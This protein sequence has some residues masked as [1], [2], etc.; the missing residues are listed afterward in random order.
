MVNVRVEIET[1]TEKVCLS[2]TLDEETYRDDPFRLALGELEKIVH[3]LR[4]YIAFK[5]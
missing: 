4:G 2:S 1:N 5:E 3:R